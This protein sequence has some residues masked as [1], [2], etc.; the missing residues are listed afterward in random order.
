[1]A[2]SGFENKSHLFEIQKVSVSSD[3]SWL[4]QEHYD[5]IVND[6]EI[7]SVSSDG[8]WLFQDW[9]AMS[10]P[11]LRK[12]QYPQTDRGFFRKNSKQKRPL[13]G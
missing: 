5:Q 4:F 1:M 6:Y 12:F 7:V 13:M 8:S 9:L 3:G 2:F 10:N 11:I